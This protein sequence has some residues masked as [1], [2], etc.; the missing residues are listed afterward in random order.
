E[1]L[2]SEGIT[3]TDADTRK[4]VVD[5]TTTRSVAI[6]LLRECIAKPELA[7]EIEAAY[8][9][10]RDMMVLDAGVVLAG[11]LLLLVLKVKRIKVRDT[12]IEFYD[13]KENALRQIRSFLGF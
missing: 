11:A 6:A 3:A 9:S 2:H 1:A 7:E 4:I 5:S 8:Q 13:V 10:R 12:E